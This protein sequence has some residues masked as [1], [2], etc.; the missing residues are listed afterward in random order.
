MG[1]VECRTEIRIPFFFAISTS[2]YYRCCRQSY[3]KVRWHIHFSQHCALLS[4]SFLTV[5]S[6]VLKTSEQA[7]VPVRKVLL[8]PAD[9][10]FAPT[11]TLLV[12]SGISSF[13]NLLLRAPAFFSPVTFPPAI[14]T[15]S[16]ESVAGSPVLLSTTRRV[17]VFFVPTESLSPVVT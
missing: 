9:V 12:G 7:T 2:C 11:S 5:A 10:A 8:T 3:L 13:F 4:S 1:H 14:K 17:V 6:S 15:V 16:L